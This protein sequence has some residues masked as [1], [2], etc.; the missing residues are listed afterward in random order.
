MKYSFVVPIFNDGYLAA[1]FCKVY[2]ETFRQFL[3]TNELNQAVELIFVNDGSKDNSTEL[4]EKLIADFGFVKVIELSRNFG[5]HIALSCG[6]HHARGEYVGMLNV[7]MEDPPSEIPKLL[8]Y[9][10]ETDFDIVLGIRPKRNSDFLI[11]ITSYLFNAFLNKLTG[12]N[13]PTNVATLRVMNRKFVN[14][15]NSLVEKSRYLP[16]LENWLGFKHGY[17]EIKHARRSSGKS[18]YS[19]S[20]RLKMAIESI[21]SFSDLPLRLITSFGFIIAILGF[22]MIAGIII[23]KL[24]FIDF[25]AGYASTL[26]AIVFFSGIQV[27]VIGTSSLYIGRILKEVQNRP[28]Y[29][30]RNKYNF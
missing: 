29:V 1:E 26:A 23:E 24:F 18:S 22:I 14:A 13:V 19:F 30:I 25:Q 15:Y 27:I 10:H 5:Q 28:L 2:Q 9:I 6:Y 21:L 12:Y 16:G 11:K 3:R 8:T 7:D 20:G 4:L 17:K